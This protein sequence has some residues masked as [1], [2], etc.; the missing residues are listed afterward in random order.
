VFNSH[1]LESI[2]MMFLSFVIIFWFIAGILRT[3]LAIPAKPEYLMFIWVGIFLQSAIFTYL[4][5]QLTY[6]D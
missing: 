1:K 2:V 3:V 5:R 6:M 4:V